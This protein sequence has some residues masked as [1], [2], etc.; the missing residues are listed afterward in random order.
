MIFVR[1]FKGY[2]DKTAQLD[3]DVNDWIVSNK[4]DVVAVN[5][6]L[7]HEPGARSGSGDLLYALVY[8]ADQP[9]A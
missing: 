3:Q 5:A 2:E 8:R 6:V 1:T 7:S 4:V 9:I